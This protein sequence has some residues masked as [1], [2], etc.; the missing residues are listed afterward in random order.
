MSS[1]VVPLVDPAFQPRDFG[2]GHRLEARRGRIG[3]IERGKIPHRRNHKF[4]FDGDISQR[5]DCRFEPF[6]GLGAVLD[7]RRRTMPS[8][9]SARAAGGGLQLF[10]N[11]IDGDRSGFAFACWPAR[12]AASHQAIRLRSV[13]PGS[14]D[15]W[16]IAVLRS[17]SPRATTISTTIGHC[18]ES[19]STRPVSRSPATG[20]HLFQ[21]AA[22]L[23]AATRR[24][25]DPLAG[26]RATRSYA[27]LSRPAATNAA[28]SHAA[29]S[30]E[31]RP[32]RGRLAA[33]ASASSNVLSAASFSPFASCCQAIAV[34]GP[35]R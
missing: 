7:R 1:C 26:N 5:G 30:T 3:K 12:S 2:Q 11:R 10:E 19:R 6:F 25:V 29:D 13:R 34:N 16:Q 15:C 27:S 33:A 28:A 9:A 35:T 32:T 24:P 17:G 18:R 21:A 8:R 23:I 20:S 31:Y 14:P 4:L 22:L